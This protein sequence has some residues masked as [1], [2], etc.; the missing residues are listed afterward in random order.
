[1]WIFS[2]VIPGVPVTFKPSSLVITALLTASLGVEPFLYA[3][4]LIQAIIL[5]SIPMLSPLKAKMYPGILRYISLQTLAL[6]LILLAGWLLS[7]VETLPSDSPLVGQSMMLLGLGFAIWLSV[8]PFHSWVPMVSK[9]SQSTVVS[10]LLFIIPTTILMFSLNFFNRY[11]FMRTSEDLFEIL[12]LFGVAMIIVGGAL[13]AVQNDLKR[14]FGFTVLSETGF[15]LLSIGLASS[16]GLSWMLAL[17]PARALGFLLWSYTIGLIENHARSTEFGKIQGYTHSYPF[18]SLGLVFAQL[19]IGGLPLLAS[20]P[21]KAV[22][23]A[24]VFNKS[25]ALGTWSLVGNLGLF[26]FSLRLINVFVMPEDQSSPIKWH[27][28]EKGYEFIPTLILILI[29]ILM[30]LFPNTFLTGIT[31]SLN[32]YGQLQ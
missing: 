24:E 31:Q 12:R 16:G 5:V 1:L 2:S 20:F 25:T 17:L 7:G 3:A 10:F 4:L 21:I 29:L 8:F 15:S 6:P 28:S 27:R 23:L 13:T 22:L 26:I 19:S 30:G 32:A 14:A 18:L 11:A 9:K